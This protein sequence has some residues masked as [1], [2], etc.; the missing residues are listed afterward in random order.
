MSTTIQMRKNGAI[1][2]PKPIRKKHAWDENGAF[3]LL[4]LDV[5]IF[6]S[7]KKSVLPKLVTQ[8]ENLRKKQG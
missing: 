3:T 2:I 1:T 6:I 8:I 5:G 4:D 7:P